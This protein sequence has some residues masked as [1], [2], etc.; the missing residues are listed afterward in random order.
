[1]ILTKLRKRALAFGMGLLGL[2]I[3]GY[4][5]AVITM[6]DTLELGIISAAVCCLPASLVCFIFAYV[7]WSEAG[8]KEENK[9]EA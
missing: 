4:G 2:S 3:I 5:F 7:I 6:A 9:K 8:G 1:M